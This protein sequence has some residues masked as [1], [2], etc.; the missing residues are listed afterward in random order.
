MGG[1]GLFASFLD[2]RQLDELILHIIPTVIGEGIPLFAPAKRTVEMTL[3]SSRRF[4]DGVV[5]LHYAIPA[6]R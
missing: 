2:A 5:R 6:R 3:L 4:A 1:A